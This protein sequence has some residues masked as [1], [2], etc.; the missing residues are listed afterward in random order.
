LSSDKYPARS[1]PSNDRSATDPSSFSSPAVGPPPRPWVSD[2]VGVATSPWAGGEEEPS[3]LQAALW[4]A[5]QGYRVFPLQP[6]QKL[7]AIKDWPKTATTDPG[8]LSSWFGDTDYNIGMLTGRPSG[9]FVIDVDPRNGGQESLDR[10]QDEHGELPWTVA[11]MTPGGG[12]HCLYSMPTERDVRNGKLTGYPGIDIKGTGGY[13]VVPPSRIGDRAYIWEDSSRLGEVPIVDAPEAILALFHTAPPS[14]TVTVAKPIPNGTRN[15]TLTS[16]AGRLRRAGWS[17]PEMTGALRALNTSRCTPPLPDEEVVQIATSVNLTDLGNA[18]RMIALHSD[19]LRYQSHAREWLHY[20]GRVWETDPGPGVMECARRTVRGIAE[21]AMEIEEQEKRAK[22]LQFSLRSEQGQRLRQMVDLAST[23]PGVAVRTEDLDRDPLLL[24]V[25]N[26]TLDLRTLKLRPH[27]AAD[28]H[29]RIAGAP[30]EP[31]AR[32]PV[33]LKFLDD[34]MDADLEL[35]Q[36]LQRAAGLCLSGETKERCF[37]VPHGMGH[38]GKS[39]FLETQRDVLGGYAAAVPAAELMAARNRNGSSPTPHLVNLPGARFATAV[40][41]EE[42]ERLAVAQLKALTGGRDTIPIRGL[43]GKSF[44]FR[45]QFKFWL[46]TNHLPRITD[47][48]ASI[49]GRLYAIPFEVQIPDP[50]RGEECDCEG[51]IKDPDLD[52]KLQAELPG[53]L[54]WMVRG[55]QEYRNGGLKPPSRVLDKTREYQR[56]EDVVGRFIQEELEIAPEFHTRTAILASRLQSWCEEMGERLTCRAVTD[57]LGKFPGVKAEKRDHAR[58]WT[59]V[60]LRG[61]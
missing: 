53:I 21:E 17:E 38:N 40:E 22:L 32:C 51:R 49:W 45:P 5:V 28:L 11:Q 4:Y 39:T 20:N 43:Y 36:F 29:T 48:T 47:P 56:R 12:S 13:I 30:Y 34:I 44:S 18:E 25:Q 61:A 16:E 27:A 52:R 54:A 41:T 7:P 24:N 26:G 57:R 31:D 50:A 10:L 58:G 8:Q 1:E 37:F 15:T 3:T 6:L 14:V 19:V 35:I 55:W 59:G 2:L 33:W 9:F 46:A 23:L 60:G 42:G